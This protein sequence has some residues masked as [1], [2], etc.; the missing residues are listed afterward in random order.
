MAD[1]TDYA[2][3]FGKQL[4][5][6]QDLIARA[7]KDEVSGIEFDSTWEEPYDFISAEIKGNK[8]IVKYT[9]PYATGSK[10]GKVQVNDVNMKADEL[11][12]F[13][14]TKYIF[15][16]V[17]RCLKKGY[18]EEGK[19][20]PM[21]ESKNMEN[22]NKQR[23]NERELSRKLVDEVR[24]G[25]GWYKKTSIKETLNEAL[26]RDEIAEIEEEA[27]EKIQ[28]DLADALHIMF[29]SMMKKWEKDSIS[30]IKRRWPSV[31][32]K[33]VWSNAFDMLNDYGTLDDI[34]QSG[35]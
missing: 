17:T 8:L 34:F 7:K 28:E 23:L 30:M 27:A 29:K 35:F 3:K 26:S 16:W 2:K 31:D 15:R 4:K 6:I 13:E 1:N 12:G 10:R 24:A 21:S 14:D 32:S 25:E 11:Y 19:P 18:K 5:K 20:F 22:S 33:R 9:E